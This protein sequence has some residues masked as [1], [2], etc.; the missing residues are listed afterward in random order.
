[1]IILTV[2]FIVNKVLIYVYLY[3]LISASAKKQTEP[4]LHAVGCQEVELVELI[5]RNCQKLVLRPQ[6]PIKNCL[7]F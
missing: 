1:M 6:I 3:C 7:Q 4:V 2:I 5:Q